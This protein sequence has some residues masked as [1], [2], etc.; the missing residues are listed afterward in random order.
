MSPAKTKIKRAKKPS[1][2]SKAKSKAKIKATK[3]A[4][5][6]PT[7]G[8]LAR[9]VSHYLIHKKVSSAISFAVII[10]AAGSIA[11]GSLSAIQQTTAD[12]FIAPATQTISQAKVLG[13]SVKAYQA[14]SLYKSKFLTLTA[15]PVN[16]SP[17]SGSWDYLINWNR[18]AGQT[19]SLSLNKK[20]IVTEADGLGSFETGYILK[21]YSLNQLIF[22]SD[23][24]GK[25]G[26][27]AG[28][29]LKVLPADASSLTVA[30]DSSQSSSG[31][32]SGTISQT[33]YGY[34]R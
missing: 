5:V 1:V 8:H 34:G 12:Q 2:R 15:T 23:L 33:D 30:P 27:V 19:G 7:W 4:V 28:S 26:V 20:V 13:L 9:H 18:A 32:G 6:K 11:A 3:S 16:Y 25:G 22:Y 14:L 24:N 21:P 17:D 29:T 10:F 31:S